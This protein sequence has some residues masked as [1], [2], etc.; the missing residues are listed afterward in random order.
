MLLRW[1]F[2][3]SFGLRAEKVLLLFW[4]WL[5]DGFGELSSLLRQVRIFSVLRFC[6]GSLEVDFVLLLNFLNWRVVSVFWRKEIIL[7]QVWRKL[8]FLL[9][10][11]FFSFLFNLLNHVFVWVILLRLIV[12]KTTVICLF[13]LNH[14]VVIVLDD[15]RLS[16]VSSEWLP[17]QRVLFN[18][19]DF[20]DL[21]I[22]H[23][24]IFA[25]V[26]V[27]IGERQGFR[28][29]IID[30]RFANHFSLDLFLW[31]FA[32]LFTLFRCLLSFSGWFRW[33]FCLLG[34]RS[35]LIFFGFFEPSWF[36]LLLWWWTPASSPGFKDF[37]ALRQFLGAA[38]PRVSHQNFFIRLLL[39]NNMRLLRWLC[40]LLLALSHAIQS[41]HEFLHLVLH[42]SHLLED[43]LYVLLI[44]LSLGNI[45]LR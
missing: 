19:R 38:I 45:D 4:K 34:F 8:R 29:Q 2:A 35:T 5:V 28:A 23:I 22:H 44:H 27:M 20:V 39:L 37:V 36:R 15:L 12:P 10:F 40:L 18:Q 24:Y 21:F 11:D 41:L 42:D 26:R 6:V 3:N 33:C 13:G 30:L 25:Q 43:G 1:Q 16:L 14:V 7:L 17:D 31:F 9:L 32:L